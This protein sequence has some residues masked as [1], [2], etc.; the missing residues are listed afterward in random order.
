[1][2]LWFRCIQFRH[3][4]KDK[5]LGFKKSTH[6]FEIKLLVII[7]GREEITSMKAKLNKLDDQINEC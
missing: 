4:S 7:G 5:A 6:L 2:I 1:M 3:G